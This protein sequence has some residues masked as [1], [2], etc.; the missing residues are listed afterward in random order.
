[1]NCRLFSFFTLISTANAFAASGLSRPS[2]LHRRQSAA[3]TMSSSVAA[4]TAATATT[5][6]L[7]DP[8]ARDGAYGGAA[9]SMNVAQYLCDLHDAKSTFDFC[10]GMMFQLV[11]SQ[12]LR[13]HLG[14]VAGSGPSKSQPVVFTQPRMGMIPDYSKAAAADNARIFHGR[15]IR[16]VPTAAGGMGFVLQLSMAEDEDPE[17]WTPAEVAGY[18]GWGHDSSRTWRKGERLEQEGFEGFRSTFGREAFALHHRFYLHLDGANRIWLSAEDG[19]EGT[20][21]APRKSFVD[22]MFGR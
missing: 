9:A 19:C 18:D 17:G 10:G 22:Q 14:E 6:Q 7:I 16:Q 11:L 5:A 21:A 12:K 8:A 13:A 3:T 2:N 20:P 15:E 4:A 1:M